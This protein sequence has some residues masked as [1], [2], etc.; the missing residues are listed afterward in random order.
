MY[1]NTKEITVNFENKDY[2][3]M[4]S[5]YL[6]DL[7]DELAIKRRKTLLIL[8]GGAYSMTSDR[9]A[10]PIALEFCAKGFNCIV[11]RYSVF[12]I[13]FP[14]SLLEVSKAIMLIREN[15]EIWNVD[16]DDIIVCGFSAGAHLA[17]CIGTLWNL[18]I[19]K[20]TLNIK[21]ELNKPS[22]LILG[23]P[24]ITSG[25]KA[26][27]ASIENLLGDKI[28]DKYYLDLVSTEKQVTKETPPTFIWH[29]YS[30][31]D[32]YVENSLLFAT[33]LAKNKVPFELHIFE[34]G[35]HGLSLASEIS[36]L[37]EGNLEKTCECWTDL[38]TTWINK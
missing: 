21:N 26:H 22:R 24:V 25:T 1:H 30:D 38:A 13:T 12:P 11:L 27:L 3:A 35:N 6:P 9:E 17:S 29:T 33:A 8:P 31:K 36:A 28:S 7:S 4:M 23:Y 34:K 20:D 5:L 19:I 14:I 32:V 37:N 10:E 16:T 2:T 15:A 18:P